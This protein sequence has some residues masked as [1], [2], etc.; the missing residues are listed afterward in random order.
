M[1]DFGLDMPVGDNSPLGAIPGFSP[2]VPT[3][4]SV[5]VTRPTGHI[6]R[7]LTN[8]NVDDCLTSLENDVMTRA[9][10]PAT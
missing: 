4:N 1:A 7:D 9:V 2:L 3:I 6:A 8:V 10:V 5:R